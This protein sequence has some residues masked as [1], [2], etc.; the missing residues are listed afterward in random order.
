MLL[1]MAADGMGERLAMGSRVDG[2]TVA[3]LTERA[4]RLGT[5][6]ADRPVERVAFIDVNSEAVPMA[7]FGAALAD[8]PFVPINYRLADDQLRDLVRRT[9]PPTVIVGDGVADRL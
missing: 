3:D 6:L 8:K 5:V 9:A 2:I 7:L 4:R 1:Q